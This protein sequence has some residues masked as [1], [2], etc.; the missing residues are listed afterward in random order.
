MVPPLAADTVSVPFM[1]ADAEGEE[2]PP[3]AAL[4][5]RSIADAPLPAPE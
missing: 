5:A 1:F 2:G 4:A 3:V